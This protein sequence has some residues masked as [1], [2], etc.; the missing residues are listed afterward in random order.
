MK[1]MLLFAGLGKVQLKKNRKEEEE[2]NA[3]R[4]R[5]RNHVVP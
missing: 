1:D 5:S 3:T 2:K 4:N